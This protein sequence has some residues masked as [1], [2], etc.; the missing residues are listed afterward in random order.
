MPFHARGAGFGAAAVLIWVFAA[1]LALI[2]G[3]SAYAVPLTTSLATPL[4]TALTT[5]PTT[6]LTTSVTEDRLTVPVK[7]EPDGIPVSL[8]VAIW[9]QQSGGPHPAVLLAHG[10]GGS[11]ADLATQGRT[12]AERGYLALGYSAR[13]FGASGGRIHLDDPDFEVADARAL[14]ALL[15]ARDDVLR[16]AAGDPRVGAVGASYGGALALMLGATD[17]RVDS[18][19]AFI[20]WHDLADAFFPQRAVAPD[21]TS[22]GTE[23]VL[24]GPFKALWAARFFGSATAQRATPDA[25][26]TSG[27]ASA[28]PADPLCGRFDPTVCRLFLD[29]TA[30]GRPSP[31]LLAMLR[32]HSPKPLL[33]GLRVPTYLVQGMADSLF[34]L[35][36]SDATARVLQAQGT[37]VAV[38]WIDGGHDGASS[39]ATADEDALAAWID[40]SLRDRKGGSGFAGVP[41]F[42]YAAPIP[43]RQSIAPLYAVPAYPSSAMVAPDSWSASANAATAPPP[44]VSPAPVIAI[45]FAQPDIRRSLA[46]PP[47]GTPA[48][49]TALGGLPIPAGGG[50]AYQLAALPG[51]SVAFETEPLTQRA[52]IV[53]SPTI[54]LRVTSTGTTSTLFL[55]LWQVTG[56]SASLP[57]KLVAPV[58]IATKPGVPA[59]VEVALPAATWTVEPGSKLRVLVSATDSAYAVPREARADRIELA[60]A[61]LRVPTLPAERVSGETETDTES[62]GVGMAILVALAGIAAVAAR[63]RRRQRREHPRPDLAD[64][65]LTVAHLVKTYADGHRAVD[66][67]SWEARR[68]QVVGLL[69]PNG[70]GKTTTLRMVMGLIA[71]DSGTAY[72][73]SQPVHPGAPALAHVGALIEG[74]GFLPHLTGMAN[75]KAYWAATGRPVADA[76]FDEVLEVAALGDAVHRPVRS[77][78]HGMKQRLGIAQAMLGLPDLLILDE[79]TN[80]LDPPQIA[81][82][83]SILQ[84][85]AAAGR[86]V[87]VSSHLL[88]EVELTCSDVVVMNAGRVVATGKVADLVDGADT[89]VLTLDPGAGPGDTTHVAQ[90]AAALRKA[91]GVTAVE[92]IDDGADPRLVVTATSPRAV[93]VR[94]AVEAGADV[95]G[96][97][98]RRHLEDVFLGVIAASQR[99]AGEPEGNSGGSAD[100]GDPARPGSAD[101]RSLS[102]RLRQVRAR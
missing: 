2:G 102:D 62:I 74:P 71:P 22:G 38:R 18:V 79:P 87:V 33:A 96:V 51:Q 5:P 52:A 4:A 1:M 94:A 20:T 85:Y 64:I 61:H 47:G 98:S 29:A 28:K 9:R 53:G 77:Y 16:D 93:V 67:V 88:A 82:M 49:V 81:A 60:D 19:A 37:P 89:T 100:P 95:A 65:P 72:L 24:P 55:T 11:V 50:A 30:S 99:G 25:S 40:G 91:D 17:P 34:D 69:G 80:G 8:D 57:R 3:P 76:R 92:V 46:N 15:A 66:D 54:R 35:S 10:F 70:A 39:T 58:N 75:L 7:A 43:R 23:P 31:E 45:P 84:R 12:L 56:E 27:A 86:T 101:Q 44:G 83:R 97:S 14:V 32:A 63:E 90:V 41:G 68:G 36:Q 78:S 73:G 48:A 13:G 6:P 21:A 26:A 42:T 59:T